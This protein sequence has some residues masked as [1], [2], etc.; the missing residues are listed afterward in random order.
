M[1]I[2]PSGAFSSRA[3]RSPL[4]GASGFARAVDDA[5]PSSIP[6]RSSISRPARPPEIWRRTVSGSTAAARS[7]TVINLPAT[8][9]GMANSTITSQPANAVARPGRLR[10]NRQTPTPRS[11]GDATTTANPA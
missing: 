10:T 9:N 3:A 5:S 7:G 11:I 4:V 1:F 2:Q 8:G 6:R